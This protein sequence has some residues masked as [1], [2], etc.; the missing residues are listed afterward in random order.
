MNIPK[1]RV[2]ECVEQ[3]HLSVGNPKTGCVLLTCVPVVRWCLQQTDPPVCPIGVE[4]L[5]LIALSSIL[6]CLPHSG[7]LFQA[8]HVLVSFIPQSLTT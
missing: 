2:L 6:E 3:G 7:P 8:L 1:H 4:G 5:I